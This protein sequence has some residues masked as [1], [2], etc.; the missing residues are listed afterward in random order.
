M[1]RLFWPALALVAALA[2]VF[3]MLPLAAL[4]L[5]VSPGKLFGQLDNGVVVDALLVSLRTSA[6]AHALVLVLGTP[7]AYLIARR[8]PGRGLLLSL[9]ELPLVL[10]PAVAGIALLAVFGR[11]GL[12]GDTLGALGIAIPFTR[13]RPASGRTSPAI[14][15]ST[16]VL[17]APD[18]PTSASVS[19]PAASSSSRA[20]WRSGTRSSTRSASIRVAP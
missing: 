9:I 16:V 1:R 13:T 10:P 3:L 17:P 2:L 12:L 14:D 5:R 6:I 8:F 19:R 20:W 4:F 18:G 7:A 15:R 11:L